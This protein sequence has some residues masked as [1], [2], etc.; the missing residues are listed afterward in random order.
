MARKRRLKRFLIN[1]YKKSWIYIKESKNFIFITMGLF[2][3]FALFGFFI[4]A[5]AYI[6]NQITNFINQLLNQTSGLSMSQLISFIFLNNIKT[7]FFGW[8][9]GFFLG[10]FPAIVAI[11]NGYVVGF[12]SATS[13]KTN[14]I[15]VLW[16]LF[17]HGI[18]ELTAVFIS[19]GMGMKLGF[20]FFIKK[21]GIFKRNFLEALRVFISVVLPLLI[22]AAIIEGSL[23]FLLG[24]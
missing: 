2:L 4:P 16:K 5:P 10:I 1:N 18:F 7:S 21:K 8:I 23:I 24:H 22:I 3:L 12:V 11:F 14:G 15:L 20:S 19:L 6:S 9:L 13:V 17:P